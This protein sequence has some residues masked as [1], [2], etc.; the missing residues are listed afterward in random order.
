MRIFS[1][2]LD[3]SPLRTG[4]SAIFAQGLK[5]LVFI[6]SLYSAGASRGSGGVFL[7]S[8]GLI[9]IGLKVRLVF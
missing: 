9:A 5:A 3:N 8:L 7:T 1:T 6:S 4:V 2:K